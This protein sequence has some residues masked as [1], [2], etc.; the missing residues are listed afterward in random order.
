M[1]TKVKRKMVNV[2]PI[3]NNAKKRFNLMDYLHGCYVD[4]EDDQQH[5]FSLAFAFFTEYFSGWSF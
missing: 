1:I 2:K 4:S 3:S 5:K